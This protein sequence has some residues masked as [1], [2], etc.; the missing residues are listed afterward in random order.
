LE[1]PEE[2]PPHFSSQQDFENS[3]QEAVLKLFYDEDK[4][5]DE[6]NDRI[7]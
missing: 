3:R 1:Q 4:N 7:I 2:V 6:Y 5:R